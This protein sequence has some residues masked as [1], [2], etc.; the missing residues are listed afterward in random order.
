MYVSACM[1]SVHASVLYFSICTIRRRP[2]CM[3][4]CTHVPDGCIFNENLN[5]I[6]FF[7]NANLGLFNI[8]YWYW[9]YW[10]IIINGVPRLYDINCTSGH[11]HTI[12]SWIIYNV[13]DGFIN[14]I[15]PRL[16][17]LFLILPEINHHWKSKFSLQT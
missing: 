14:T 8:C 3:H 12:W 2:T 1:Q 15:A 6:V 13:I 9:H 10:H 5:Y 4:T 16:L 11:V 17:L 7:F